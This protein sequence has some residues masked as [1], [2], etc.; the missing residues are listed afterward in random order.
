MAD[1]KITKEDYKRWLEDEKFALRLLNTGLRTW[2]TEELT[3]ITAKLRATNIVGQEGEILSYRSV[4]GSVL[5][6]LENIVKRVRH[7]L[8]DRYND[9]ARYERKIREMELAEAE[10]FKKAAI[11]A[12]ADKAGVQIV[13]LGPSANETDDGAEQERRELEWMETEPEDNDEADS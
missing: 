2:L 1:V 10:E 12:E 7:E 5:D 9:I 4:Y 3:R 11:Q 8:D 6:D 13:K